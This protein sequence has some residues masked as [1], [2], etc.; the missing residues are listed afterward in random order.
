M[1][2][3]RISHSADIS[4]DPYIIN[5][6]DKIEYAQANFVDNNI[7]VISAKAG[8]GKTTFAKLLTSV[9]STDTVW[10]QITK[11]DCDPIYFCSSLYKKIKE[12]IN[13][14][15]SDVLDS[16]IKQNA[17]MITDYPRYIK[18]I[19]SSLRNITK[20]VIIVID[21]THILPENGLGF[22][23]LQLITA[24]AS[25]KI[26]FIL[27]T[28]THFTPKSNKALHLEENFLKFS[29]NEFK[30]LSTK[31]LS[32][33]SD[34]SH[35]RNIEKLTDGWVMGLRLIYEH[36]TE[37]R[38]T[39]IDEFKSIDD[40]LD[41][42]FSGAASETKAGNLDKN[43]LY[44]SFLNDI[45]IDFI[46]SLKNGDKTLSTIMNMLEKNFFVQRVTE[47]RIRFHHMFGD[48]LS[49]KA[50]NT[51]NKQAISE[52]IINAAEFE[53]GQD[54]LTNALEYFIAADNCNK[55][56]ALIKSRFP[57]FYLSTSKLYIYDQ[58]KMIQKNDLSNICWT[59]M[60]LGFLHQSFNPA[61]ALHTLNMSSNEAK[62]QKDDF[63][64]ALSIAGEITYH[65]YI[66]GDFKTVKIRH[67]LLQSLY[68]KLVNINQTIEVI[69]T[70]ALSMGG[71]Y[72]ENSDISL[73]YIERVSELGHE[74]ESLSTIILADAMHSIYSGMRGDIYTQIKRVNNVY[75]K[76]NNPI[77]AKF[78]YFIMLGHL[79]NHIAHMGKLID[80]SSLAEAIKRE[81]FSVLFDTFID[82]WYIDNYVSKGM[83]DEAE[84]IIF[85]YPQNETTDHLMSQILYYKALVQ[86]IKGDKT[87]LETVS[88]SL[89][90]RK[91]SGGHEYFFSLNYQFIGAVN[92]LLG[93][94]DEA[95]KYLTKSIET[96]S[97]ASMDSGSYMFMSWISHKKG[98]IDQAISFAF[99]AAQL[100][101]SIN[102]DY[103]WGI[104]FEVYKS[105]IRYAAMTPETKKFAQKVAEEKF[106]SF[107]DNKFE[108]KPL[109]QI[110]TFGTLE[111]YANDKI[112]NSAEMTQTSKIIISILLCKNGY[113]CSVEEVMYL[114]WPDADEQKARKSF[115]TAV[116]R[117]RNNIKEKLNIEAKEYIQVK[118]GMIF[119]EK[120]KLDTEIFENCTSKCVKHLKNNEF[121]QSLENYF[122]AASVYSC[123]FLEP[124]KG[125]DIIS[126]KQQQYEKLFLS[127]VSAGIAHSEYL[128]DF[129]DV[130][131]LIE[132][133]ISSH[134]HLYDF[135]KKIVDYY[136]SKGLSDQ[137]IRIVE[138]YTE[139]L[140]SI[141]TDETEIDNI[142]FNLK[143]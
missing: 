50:E 73:K 86:S 5:R 92:A 46:T 142:I 112:I 105:F 51:L 81:R 96:C 76:M 100:L 14:Y 75:L 89:G 103:C 53:A 107:I 83:L 141:Y 65:T 24:E 69:I 68:N 95:I 129:F 143:S 106:D 4:D 66:S 108:F 74:R 132:K 85:R 22:G 3:Y 62:K 60:L 91:I 102:M 122:K 123:I 13:G 27:N 26:K 97:N 34:F 120:V 38:Q 10:Y 110:K 134:L 11:S 119:L 18:M 117:L 99:K 54:E 61:E 94:D 126:A 84:E 21:D 40:F 64:L 55:L 131:E 78:D 35:L 25:Q 70:S 139:H 114:L 1:R 23:C 133:H 71:I 59:N 43:L 56:E 28:R 116:T 36:M 90:M 136:N 87:A 67:D 33:L 128:K 98:N 57:E 37:N 20:D 58:L 79:L 135:I 130:S 82:I 16:I 7:C 19:F 113:T 137:V 32:W 121:V 42:Y 80:H 48:L 125:L 101:I 2:K 8:Q 15:K 45:H 118:N 93:N 72:T 63:C 31:H 41:V 49:K 30:Q 77:F 88:K 111:I 12:D 140:R 6:K 47:N 29:S 17:L 109:L 44:L 9:Q 104:T 115:D 39:D 124:I 138:Q 127:L 52:F